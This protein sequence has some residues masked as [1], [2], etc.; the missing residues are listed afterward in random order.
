MDT[1]PAFLQFK[2]NVVFVK[3]QYDQTLWT[4]RVGSEYGFVRIANKLVDI[5]HDGINEVIISMEQPGDTT[6][7][8]KNYGLVCYDKRK[9]LI[10]SY[11]FQDY[12]ETADTKHSTID[13]KSVV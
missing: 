8:E 1:N 3:N 12:V 7:T 6:I 9:N 4:T 11:T 13:R 5:N 2:N 10:W